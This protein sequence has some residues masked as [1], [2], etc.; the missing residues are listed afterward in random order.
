MGLPM[1]AGGLSN[2]LS[3]RNLRVGGLLVPLPGL[4]LVAFMD[5]EYDVFSYFRNQCV[6][7][8]ARD[9]TLRGWWLEARA[10]LQP[11]AP[12]GGQPDI[13][14]I[15]S[16]HSGYLA[17]VPKNPHY[18]MTVESMAASFKLVEIA[19]LLAFQFHVQTDT[20][21]LPVYANTP[22]PP[23]DK[24][25]RW[26]LPRF[27]PPCKTQV[28]RVDNGW[29]ITS[30]DVNLAL[31]PL[32]NCTDTKAIPGLPPVCYGPR[33]P[34]VQVVRYRERLY[35]KNGYHR[36]YQLGKLGYTHIPCILLDATIWEQVVGPGEVAAF[37]LQLLES[38]NPP[39]CGHF[40]RGEAYPI[41]LPRRRQVIR[42]QEEAW[43]NDLPHN[44]QVMRISAR[45]E[46]VREE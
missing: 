4:S 41:T 28:D 9:E 14:E 42:L 2:I 36:A 16:K 17:G 21:W 40:L 15:P 39:T 26:C 46:S 33:S 30:D 29:C 8:N 19:P 35:L 38:S 18:A 7:G 31:Y 34:F 24:I 5:D 27:S 10:L 37:P 32:Q 1:L 23:L 12:K 43:P 22:N 13:R 20:A 11:P 6:T 3:R 25:L 44:P 45:L